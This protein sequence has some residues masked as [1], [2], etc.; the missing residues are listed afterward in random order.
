MSKMTP[1]P[2]AEV[3]RHAITSR[4]QWLKLR[5]NDL[6]ASDIG[7]YLGL[8]PW[9][10]PAE[11]FAEK[12]G[13]SPQLENENAVLRRG[14]RDEYA[15]LRI[16]AEERPDWKIS[17]SKVY[18]RDPT[19]RLGCTPDAVATDPKREGIGVVQC[20][21]VAKDVFDAK[22][23]IDEDRIDIPIP[24]VLQ[25]LCEAHLAGASWAV[26]A[27]WVRTAWTEE[28]YILDVP[29][30]PVTVENIRGQAIKFWREIETGVVPQLDHQRDD[31]VIE[32]FHPREKDEDEQD[33][34]T[35]NEAAVM[36]AEFIDV[37][38]QIAD[39]EARKKALSAAL[40]AK[41]GDHASAR[42]GDGSKVSWRTMVRPEH[43]V[44]E[45]SGRILR[46]TAPRAKKASKEDAE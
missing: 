27:A 5:L 44:D 32:L 24:Y 45:W 29:I 7:A 22:W 23:R 39:L 35:A 15:I 8:T 13:L 3:E 25:T 2:P 14:R 9:K 43:L 37:R 38:T 36:V 26:L 31:R 1:P 28:L 16:I 40:K 10:S 41:L 20:K 33:W 4:E 34:S 19:I 17:E 18:L 42:L 6:T 46:V 11:L 30:D 21:S 12:I